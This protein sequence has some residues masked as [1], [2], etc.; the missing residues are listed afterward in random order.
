MGVK[1]LPMGRRLGTMLI[2]AMIATL[3]GLAYSQESEKAAAEDRAAAKE[4]KSIDSA[5]KSALDREKKS[6]PAVS[7]AD[8]WGGVRE[9][10]P[11]QKKPKPGLVESK[12]GH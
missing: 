5:Y 8:P 4:R 7:A 10:V 1:M 6:E 9:V 2:A 3:P 11:P 12:S